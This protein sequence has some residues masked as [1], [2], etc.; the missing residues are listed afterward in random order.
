MSE[1]PREKSNVVELAVE[2]EK[3]RRVGGDGTEGAKEGEDQERAGHASVIPLWPRLGQRLYLRFWGDDP[4]G[5]RT[6]TTRI[7][8]SDPEPGT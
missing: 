2:R 6:F 1:A 5:E 3:R 4:L 8:G 7:P